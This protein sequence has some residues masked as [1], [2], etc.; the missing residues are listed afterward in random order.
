MFS[1][2]FAEF[3][4]LHDICTQ[5]LDGSRKEQVGAMTRVIER[6][7]VERQHLADICLWRPAG[8]APLRTFRFPFEQRQ[9]HTKPPPQM[10]E[11]ARRRLQN[12]A[13]RL[14]VRLAPTSASRAVKPIKAHSF[15]V[16]TGV[17]TGVTAA[18][19]TVCVNGTLV[20]AG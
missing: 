12:Q 2:G 18:S 4:A 13:E 7:V 16:G 6:V 10:Q 3:M 17:A 19:A 20:V 9:P 11:A 1:L 5:V 15:S 14:R 8:F